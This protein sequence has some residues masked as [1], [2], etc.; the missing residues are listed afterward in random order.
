MFELRH[1]YFNICFLIIVC[2]NFVFLNSFFPEY[3]NSFLFIIGHLFFLH[4]HTSIYSLFLIF[5]FITYLK[6]IPEYFLLNFEHLNLFSNFGQSADLLFLY[7]LFSP[8]LKLL[9][10]FKQ[11]EVDP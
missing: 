4:A 3:L 6:I 11:F 2:Q 7:L 8:F 5:Y 10:C 9:N 1:P